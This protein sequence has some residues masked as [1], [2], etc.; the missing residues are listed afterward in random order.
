MVRSLR[1]T[2]LSLLAAT[3]I[4]TGLVGGYARADTEPTSPSLA[5]LAPPS[6]AEASASPDWVPTPAGLTYSSCVHEVPDGAEV[7]ADGVVSVNGTAVSSIPACPYSGIVSPDASE[8]S[9]GA[10]STPPPLA[11]GWWLN[12]WW[13]SASQITSLT[14]KWVVPPAPS[15]NGALIYLFP[16]VEPADGSAI[17]QPVLQWGVSPAGGGNSWKLA[18]WYVRGG[19]ALHSGLMST[20]AGHTIKRN[21]YPGQRHH[22]H[23]DYSSPR[24]DQ[25]HVQQLH[26]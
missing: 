2:L 26:R 8:T 11:D 20:T 22:D 14:S 23:L 25:W 19:T 15:S 4:V 1:L 5:Q 13:T 18:N 17:V 16:S 21:P 10:G 7:S 9:A 12:S 24:L 3:L 6:W